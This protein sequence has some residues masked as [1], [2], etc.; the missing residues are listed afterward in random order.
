MFVYC[1]LYTIVCLFFCHGVACLLSTNMSHWYLSFL[2]C[3]ML[4]CC[5]WDMFVWTT[6]KTSPAKWVLNSNVA[7]HHLVFI[8][9]EFYN[10]ISV[11]RL[12]LNH[13]KKRSEWFNFFYILFPYDWMTE[14]PLA[15]DFIF[16]VSFVYR[17][18][19]GRYM[20]DR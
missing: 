7:V 9:A 2:F 20:F 18:I 15:L 3:K 14:F 8:C 4:L 13:F 12:F 10:R 16:I 17:L 6:P 5:L 1:C 11:N 19:V